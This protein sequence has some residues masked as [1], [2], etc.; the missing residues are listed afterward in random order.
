MHSPLATSARPVTTGATR[1]AVDKPQAMS[2]AA[3]QFKSLLA[4]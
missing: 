3:E 4:N 2:P 1:V